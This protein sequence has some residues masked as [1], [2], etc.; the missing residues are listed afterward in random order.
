MLGAPMTTTTGESDTLLDIA[1]LYDIGFVAIREANPGIDPWMPGAGVSIRVP[2]QHI[3]PD[4]PRAGIVINLPEL[5]LYYFS[6]HG[7]V[8]SFPI[9][10]GDEGKD[11]PVGSTKIARKLPHPTWIPTKSEHAEDADLPDVVGPGPDNPMGDFALYLAWRGYAIHGTNK[12]DSIG[13]RDSHG[14]I[15]LYPEDIAWLYAQVRQGTPV[16]IVNQPAKVAWLNGELYL[17][18]HPQQEDLNS[19][20]MTGEPLSS[21]AIDADALILKAAGARANQLDWYAIHLAEARRD[22]IPLRITRPV[23][24]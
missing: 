9:G 11:T 10:T 17:E 14:C 16:T 5:R 13:R 4:A 22:G 1:R 15:R 23:S 21:E 3:L 6:P 18:V 8:R 24:G 12:P 2:T 7:D 20:E 19:I